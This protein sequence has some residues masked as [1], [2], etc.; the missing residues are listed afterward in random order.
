MQDFPFF[1]FYVWRRPRKEFYR[2]E[3]RRVTTH[4]I[5]TSFSGIQTLQK[6]L[7]KQ[8]QKHTVRKPV[9][10]ECW[11]ILHNKKVTPSACNRFRPFFSFRIS[12]PPLG[13]I[14]CRLCQREMFEILEADCVHT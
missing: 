14:V 12:Q 10:K 8:K 2:P 9:S 6:L 7:D 11:K 3:T 5:F 13:E 1:H 4:T